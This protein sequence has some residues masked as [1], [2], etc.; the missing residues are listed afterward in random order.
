MSSIRCSRVTL[1]RSLL[2][3]A[4]RRLQPRR[5]RVDEKFERVANDSHADFSAW[6]N[7]NDLRR[8]LRDGFFALQGVETA[9]GHPASLSTHGVRPGSS[10]RRAHRLALPLLLDTTAE[11][12]MLPR[13]CGARNAGASLV[14]PR[15]GWHSLWIYPTTMIRR[16]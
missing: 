9:C 4:G 6:S 7:I 13:C 15:V 2:P 16:R 10:G 11:S 1:V 12:G 8:D 3:L 5:H 14:V